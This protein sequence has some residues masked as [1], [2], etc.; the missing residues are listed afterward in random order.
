VGVGGDDLVVDARGGAR[1]ADDTV[2]RGAKDF[3][4]ISGGSQHWTGYD[5]ETFVYEEITGDFDKV[6]RVEYQ[7]P[8]TQWSRAG[9]DA[10]EALDAGITR[11]EQTAGYKFSQHLTVRVNPPGIVGWD[12]RIGNNLHEVIHRPVEGM[13]YDGFNAMFNILGGANAAP[14]Y[15]NAWIRLKREGQ[16][17]TSFLSSNGT[18]WTPIGNVTYADDAASPENEILA[19]KLFV[20]MFY[21]PEFNN[22]AED[23]RFNF[24]ASIAKFRDYGNFSTGP[25]PGGGPVITMTKNG[26]Q[27]T[28]SW[29]NNGTLQSA[30]S[31]TGPWTDGGTTSPQTVTIVATELARFYRVRAN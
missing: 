12:G 27:L 24:A 18:T 15:P 26:N 3:D 17:L 5:E 1:Y 29:T 31:L 28:I 25:G 23:Q 19:D 21:G 11:D 16:K 20:G 7:D 2:A 6:V 30:T 10:R 9:L 14:T 8:V 13:N 4:L 22:I